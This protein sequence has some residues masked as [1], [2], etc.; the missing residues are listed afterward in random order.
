MTRAMIRSKISR[1]DR[2]EGVMDIS[3]PYVR[4]LQQP[5]VSLIRGCIKA[6]DF[7]LWHGPTGTT[8]LSGTTVTIQ[9]VYH[10]AGVV[11][12]TRLA[13]PAVLLGLLPALSLA[14]DPPSSIARFRTQE[15]EKGLKI[16]YA[17]T[18]ADLNGDGK[19]DII[20]VDKHRVVW[21]E[22]PSWKMRTILTGTTKPDNVCICTLDID[23]DGQLDIVL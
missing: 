15:F 22:N 8:T 11:T 10:T 3:E 6:A 1:D 9:P 5:I 13:V 17:V 4:V 14:A 7:K 12:M 2:C 16:G 21:Y 18:V 19:P 20:V 23:G